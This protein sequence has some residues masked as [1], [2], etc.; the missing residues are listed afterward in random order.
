MRSWFRSLYGQLFLWAILPI[1]FVII[2]VAS[3]G[4]YFHQRSM[5]DFVAERDLALA[6]LVAQGIAA[7]LADGTVMADGSGLQPWIS[8]AT[9]SPRAIVLVVDGAGTVLARA[10]ADHPVLVA[11]LDVA[12][13][14]Q[15]GSVLR[16]DESG[17]PVLIVFAA[18][19][20]TNWSVVVREPVAVL[21]DPALRLS[22]LGPIAALSAGLFSV[23]VLFFGWRTIVR[24]L[25]QLAGAAGQVSWGNAVAVRESVGGVQEVRDLQQALVQMVEHIQG[26]EAGIRDYL[27]AMTE[28]QETERARLARELHDGPVQELVVLA[29]RAEM[30]QR[31][32]QHGDV[33]QTQRRLAEIQAL[34]RTVHEELRR[35]MGALRPVYLEDLGFLPALEMLAQQSGDEGPVRVTLR[36]AGAVPR[37]SPEVELTAYRIAQEALTNALHHAGTTEVVIRVCYAEGRLHLAIS[38]TGSGFVLPPRPDVLTREGHFGLVGMQERA[39]RLGGVLEI[40]TALGGGTTIEAHLPGAPDAP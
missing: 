10:G 20:D 1:T 32:A 6:H 34:A 9:P 40:R 19:P 38:D 30:A 5:R 8:A 14:P 36:I 35:L 28:G 29:Q 24:P 15:E 39:T 22:G 31:L 37:L 11:E 17:L 3:T 16:Q 25:R 33:A 4:V 2:A 13:G 12:L 21:D 7:G 23:L 27:A 26:Y 18:V